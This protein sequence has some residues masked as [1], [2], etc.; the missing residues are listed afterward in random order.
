MGAVAAVPAAVAAAHESVFRPGKYSDNIAMDL[1]S[2]RKIFNHGD[3][4]SSQNSDA[5]LTSIVLRL[6]EPF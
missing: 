2:G 6:G 5:E 4:S 3:L 1:G